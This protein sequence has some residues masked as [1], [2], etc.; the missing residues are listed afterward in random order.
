[1]NYS[2]KELQQVLEKL[3]ALM[4]TKIKNSI[5]PDAKDLHFLAQVRTFMNG[6]ANNDTHKQNNRVKI[7]TQLKT[8]LKKG[9]SWEKL[10]TP[11]ENVSIIKVPLKKQKSALLH[12]VIKFMKREIDIKNSEIFHKLRETIDDLRVNILVK[13][14]DT[15]NSM[16]L[17]LAS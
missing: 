8:F 13:E 7:Q 17:R 11:I 9:E 12:L 4:N 14:I 16:K 6:F 5:T 10:K 1:M 3:S 2:E 15:I